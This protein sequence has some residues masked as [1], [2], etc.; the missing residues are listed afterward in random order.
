MTHALQHTLRRTACVLAAALIAACGGIDSPTEDNGGPSTPNLL[1]IADVAPTNAG[2]NGTVL[3]ASHTG[4]GTVTWALA[5]GS[6]GSLSATSGD[7]VTYVPPPV[8]TIGA[9]T[10]V[11]VTATIGTVSKSIVITVNPAAAGIYLAAGSQNGFGSV[12]GTGSAARVSFLWTES[13][14]MPVDVAGNAY[15]SD[16]TNGTIRRM[17]PQGVVSTHAGVPLAGTS[18]DGPGASASFVSPDGMAIDGS[19]NLYVIDDGLVRK[20]TPDGVVSTVLVSTVELL[21]IAVDAPGNIY[22]TSYGG[23]YRVLP[24][25]TLGLIAGRSGTAY[26]DGTGPAAGFN[27]P[28]AVV[29]DSSGNLIVADTENHAIR[30]VTQAGV[31]TTLAGQQGQSGSTDGPGASATFMR[32]DGIAIDRSGRIV[33]SDSGNQTLRVLTRSGAQVDVATLAGQADN[34]HNMLASGRDGSGTA[35]RF[36]LPRGLGVDL[37]GNVLVADGS[38]IRKV[39]PAGAVTTAAGVLMNV[40]PAD[41]TGSAAG[42][43]WNFSGGTLWSDAAGNVIYTDELASAVRRIAPSGAVTTIAGSIGTAGHADGSAGAARFTGPRG[44]VGD[45]TG[46]LYVADNRNYVIRKIAPD[47]TVSTLAGTA[48]VRGTADGTGTAARFSTLSGMAIDAAGDMYVLEFRNTGQAI[49]KVTPAGVVTTVKQ[50]QAGYA[51]ALAIDGAGNLYYP[52]FDKSVIWKLAPDGTE[53][54]LA[55]VP[56]AIG[57]ADGTGANARFRYPN[58]LTIDPAGNLYVIEPF[59]GTIRKITPAGVVTT[60]AGVA[61]RY[62]PLGPSAPLPGLVPAGWVIRYIGNNTL[63]VMA[64]GG[65]YKIVLP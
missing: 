37:D 65:L 48:G 23:V 38:A 31:V 44:A 42:F 29:V 25:G 51:E 36:M 27:R 49:R 26:A 32:P 34:S 9:P 64:D 5:A 13:Y 35:A 33:V 55:G 2:A 7:S 10:T 57:T 18:V 62:G 61:G 4:S 60:V 16:A 59:V 8:G 14:S 30:Q 28:Y 43:G 47:G 52:D 58:G 12:D 17:T 19:G 22:I 11:T 21:A 3:T 24:G 1:A 53:T 20:I 40:T 63:A 39:T 6:P 50:L 15:F 54:V 41:G 45:A 56:D 46:N